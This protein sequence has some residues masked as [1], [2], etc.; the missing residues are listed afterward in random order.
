MKIEG[1][2]IREIR[3]CE[4]MKI[5]KSPKGQFIRGT[6]LFEINFTP[7]ICV[8]FSYILYYMCYEY[9]IKQSYIRVLWISLQII[10]LFKMYSHFKINF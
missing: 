9:F 10:P 5:I 2:P 7:F 6:Q 1:K 4:L 3:N 8:W